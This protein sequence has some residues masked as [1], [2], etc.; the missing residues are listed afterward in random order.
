MRK[1]VHEYQAI[2]GKSTHFPKAGERNTPVEEFVDLCV[3]G[4]EAGGASA[5]QANWVLDVRV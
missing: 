2:L 5:D 4:W 1:V 3:A